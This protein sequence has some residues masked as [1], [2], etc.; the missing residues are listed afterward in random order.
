MSISGGELDNRILND[1]SNTNRVV[2]DNK[3]ATNRV[4]SD[5]KI[6]ANL[7]INGD[8]D[9]TEFTTNSTDMDISRAVNANI[10]N[11]AINSGNNEG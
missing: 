4:V 5:N 10:G 6:T 8:V 7:N 1:G 9:N 2:S 11:A 3:M